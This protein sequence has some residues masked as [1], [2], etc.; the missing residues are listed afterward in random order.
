MTSKEIISGKVDQFFRS[1]YG[2]LLS[3][4]TAK[5]GSGSISFAEDIAQETLL[6]AFRVWRVKG[7]P[8]NVTAWLFT[9]AKNKSYNFLQKEK[10]KQ[11]LHQQF[12]S[13]RVMA[14]FQ[15]EVVLDDEIED[16]VLKLFFAC[17]SP[18]IPYENQILIILNTLCG[19]S[20][21]EIANALLLKEETVKKRL[22]RV[23]RM[24]REN[25]SDFTIPTGKPLHGKLNA[26]CQAIYLLFNEGYYS[27]N[28]NR[29]IREEVCL[30]AIRLCKLIVNHFPED[31][32][33]KALLA[34]MFFHVARFESRISPEGSIVL[35]EEQNRKLWDKRMIEQ[36]I[37]YLSEASDQEEDLSAIH[38]EAHIAATHCTTIDFKRTDWER[39][40]KLYSW[41][42]LFKP[43]PI[44]KLNQ[45]I[46]KRKLEGAERGIEYLNFLEREDERLK[47]NHLFYAAKAKFYF[48][49]KQFDNAM[50]NYLRA[51]RNSNSIKEKELF[52]QKI[53]DC[54]SKMKI[55]K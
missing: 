34:L 12:S 32:K 11:V 47:D 35:F 24:L 48:D 5:F 54:R 55:A 45:A 14:A 30:E 8:E 6:E 4:L 46:V 31:A 9:V 37:Y 53:K 38:L 36:G 42:Y 39:I 50:I 33:S 44:I 7:I 20:R 43:S 22:F 21:K 19:F 23:K 10:R 40:D 26:V 16:S 27:S 51:Q 41:L 29:L 52:T 25:Q 49:L 13:E 2:K 15:T 3:Y 1:E 17:C 28:E 18:L